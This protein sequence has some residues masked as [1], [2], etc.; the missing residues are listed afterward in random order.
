MGDWSQTIVDAEAGPQDADRLAARVRDWLV[1][2]GI[3]LAERT[4]CVLGSELGHPPG[5]NAGRALEDPSSDQ[6]WQGLWTNGLD[7]TVGRR[8]FD[9]GQGE[10]E[11]VTCPHC[12]KR[13]RLDDDH[14]E[15]WD[16]ISD[17]FD[18]WLT[19]RDGVVACPSCGR[20]V[21]PAAW[22]WPGDHF[23]LGHL[24]F[25]FWNWPPLK[26]DFVAEVG[27][28]LGGHRVVLLEGKL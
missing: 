21:E 23:A 19:G 26:Q 2:A 20:E 3:V 24:G 17:A 9:A 25:Q 4:D 27:R 5:P 8:V 18:E 16:L 7:I 13:I 28:R 12:A 10:V 1:S 6:G 22:R 14:G 15:A 11:A